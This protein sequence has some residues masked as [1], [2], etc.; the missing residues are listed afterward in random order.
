M[1]RAHHCRELIVKAG[2]QLDLCFWLKVEAGSYI[3]APVLDG[4][5]DQLA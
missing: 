4:G 5:Y 2:S 1:C 3:G